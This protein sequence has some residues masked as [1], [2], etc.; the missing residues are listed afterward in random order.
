M[1]FSL[2]SV[3]LLSLSTLLGGSLVAACSASSSSSTLGS[4]AG[5]S[6]GGSSGQA[7]SSSTGGSSASGGT[8]G[9]AFDASTGTG[10]G[11]GGLQDG[12]ACTGTTTKSTQLPLDIYVMMDISGSMTEQ[13]SNGQTKWAAVKSAM[14]GFLNDKNSQ[15]L[16]VGIQYF[17]LL[18]S[19]VPDTCTSNADCGTGGLCVLKSCFDSSAAT[20]AVVPCAS[21][22]DCSG[23]AQCVPL[24]QNCQ[25]P[26]QLCA[27]ATKNCT[28]FAGCKQLT[29]SYCSNKTQCTSSDYAKPAV[30]ISTLGS[31]TPIINSMNGQTPNGQTPTAPALQGAIDHATAWAKAHP[32]HTVVVVMAT[33]GLPTQCS[34][35]DI[36][37]IAGIASN[38]V[39]ATPGIDTFVIGVFAPTDTTAQSNLDTIAK[40][41][42]TGS[43]FIVDTSGNVGQ[44]FTD[45]LNKIRG[46]ALAC[47]FTLPAPPDGGTLDYGKVNVSFT[48]NGKTQNLLYVTDQSHCDPN[49]GGWYYDHDP[50]NGGTPTKIIVCDNNCADFK[51]TTSTTVGS[52]DVQLGCKTN[53]PVP[54]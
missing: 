3:L 23:A 46:Q 37:S 32:T 51:T 52:V 11:S 10:G 18:D 20:H 2:R 38:A 19:S 31:P 26:Q 13:L 40:A 45:A 29:T 53:T 24:G 28:G 44:Q 50:A 22:A 42:G 41:G 33:D 16:G 17:P 35:T 6:T 27:P 21:N 48:A 8:G 14:T 43:A 5:S 49:T 39:K 15:G 7:G 30:E 12:G 9:F 4:G 36:P 34:P 1:A 25:N 54:Q 47:D